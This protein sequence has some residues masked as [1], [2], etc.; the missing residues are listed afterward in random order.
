[1]PLPPARLSALFPY[2]T[3]FRSPALLGL[4]LLQSAAGRSVQP[5]AGGRGCVAPAWNR[6]ARGAERSRRPGLA[7]EGGRDRR[8]APGEVKR[9]DRKSTRLNS[10]HRTSSYAVF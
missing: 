8:R 1:S 5:H 7:P 3:L 10:S 6:R 4:R 9:S 2:T